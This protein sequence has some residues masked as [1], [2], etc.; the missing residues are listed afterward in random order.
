MNMRHFDLKKKNIYVYSFDFS[1]FCEFKWLKFDTMKIED[2]NPTT[3]KI[4]MKYFEEYSLY[5]WYPK[6]VLTKNVEKKQELFIDLLNDYIFKDVIL[7]LGEKEII[8]FR[9]F[10]KL[11]ASKVWSLISITDMAWEIWVIRYVLEKYMFTLENTF[12]IS[13]VDWFKWWNISWEIT[14]LQ[15]VY[16]KDIWFLRYFLWFKEWTWD[17]KWKMVENF[18][19]NEISINKWS[20]HNIYFWC[21]KNWTEVDFILQDNFNWQLIPIEVKSWNKDNVPKSYKNFIDYYKKIIDKWVVTV[22]DFYK[23]RQIADKEIKF[24]S[25][26]LIGKF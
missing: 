9:K 7:L 25:Y 26:L 3:F 22:S 15:K 12:I 8:N 11:L 18:I 10:L 23:T 13:T 16:F 2:I 14:K 20:K 4:L 17:Y 6:V 19:L 24:I 5:G 21:R 1:E